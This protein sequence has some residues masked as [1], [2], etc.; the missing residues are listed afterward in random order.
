MHFAVFHARPRQPSHCQDVIAVHPTVTLFLPREEFLSLI[1]EHP[2]ILQ[3]L[4]L[5]AVK[6]DEE[7]SGV[8]ENQTTSV[9]EDYV[10]V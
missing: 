1:G 8:L 3:G 2:A 4:Y 9:A 10:L 5:L 6:R 7:T